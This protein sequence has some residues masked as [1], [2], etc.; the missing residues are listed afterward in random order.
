MSKGHYFYLTAISAVLIVAV[1]GYIF[2]NYDFQE[3]KYKVVKD[4]VEFVSN[5]GE[6]SDMLAGMKTYPSFIV[7][8]QLVKQGPENSYM[9]RSITLFNAVLAGNRVNNVLVVRVVDEKGD[10]MECQ[11]NLG[12]VKGYK[13]LGPEEC[14]QLIS[15][16]TSARVFIELPDEK[17]SSPKV[18][19]EKGVVRIYPSTYE[20]VS[21][22]SFAVLNALYGNAE[23]IISKVNAAVQKV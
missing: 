17:L 8:P 2:I 12:D 3:Y 21:G 9:T 14:N 4:G 19:L 16:S 7:S 20:S 1:A 15:D 6:P 11:T 13:T 23:E 10:I 22:V 5:E 18:V